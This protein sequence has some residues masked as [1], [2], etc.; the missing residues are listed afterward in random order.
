MSLRWSSW[1]CRPSSVFATAS[2]VH[3]HD[4]RPCERVWGG[5]ERGGGGGARGREREKP[6]RRESAQE[7][8]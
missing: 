5:R 4:P 2:I 6:N 3:V 1:C 7:R 8:G